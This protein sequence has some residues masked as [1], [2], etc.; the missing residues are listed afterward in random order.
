MNNNELIIHAINELVNAYAPY[1]GFKVGA[2]ILTKS[3]KVYTGCNIENSSFS[4]TICAERTAI[5]KAISEGEKEFV[6]I[7]IIAQKD[8]KMLSVPPCGICLQVMS[9]FCDNNFDVILASSETEYKIFK[10]SDLLPNCFC[11]S[12]VK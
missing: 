12:Y 4:A 10:L 11:K 1:S 3:N 8:D 2:A 7:A 5:F 9:E 6:S